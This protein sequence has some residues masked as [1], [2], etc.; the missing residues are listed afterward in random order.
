MSWWERPCLQT[1]PGS[2]LP[3]EV[4]C[5]ARSPVLPPLLPVLGFLSHSCPRALGKLLPFQQLGVKAEVANC[6]RKED[7]GREEM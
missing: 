3:Q 6:L 7:L 5:W 2:K 1:A 4:L